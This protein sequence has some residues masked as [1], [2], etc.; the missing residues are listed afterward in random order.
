MKKTY[1][2]NIH[3]K[4]L[5][6]L[7]N[8]NRQIN[9]NNNKIKEL[10]I[11][12]KVNNKN[13]GK[14]SLAYDLNKGFYVESTEKYESYIL[15]LKKENKFLEFT[16]YESCGYLLPL[17]KTA[18]EILELKKKIHRIEQEIKYKNEMENILS[19]YDFL[20]CIDTTTIE[21]L[22]EDQVKLSAQLELKIYEFLKECEIFIYII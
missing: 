10:E 4:N 19:E 8:T 7:Y 2:D 5:M 17:S 22:E 14:D 20:Q 15:M 3:Y 11:S 21:G 16:N 9:I 12:I 18:Q 6:V 13:K 1:L